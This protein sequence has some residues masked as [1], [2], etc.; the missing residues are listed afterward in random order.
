MNTGVAELRRDAGDDPGRATRL[1]DRLRPADWV[2]LTAV[3]G[4]VLPVCVAL[5]GRLGSHW[6]PGGD[7]AVIARLS[8]DVLSGHPPLLGM[9]STIA[10][11]IE[12]PGGG[13]PHHL[14]PMLFWLFAIPDRLSGSSPA[15]LVITIALVNIAAI[16]TIAWQVR[17]RAGSSAAVI[18]MLG[19]LVLLWSVGRDLTV[20]IWNPYAALLP[21][22][23]FLVLA[24]SVTCA[25]HVAVPL[26]VLVGSFVMQCHILY[27]LPVVGVGLVAAAA[28]VLRARSSRTQ[29]TTGT[30]E[31]ERRARRRSLIAAA[32][33]LSLCWSTAVYDQV[34]HR[35]GNLTRLWN[36]F[37]GTHQKAFGTV[38]AY[39]YGMRAIAVPPL[40]ARRLTDYSAFIALG[41]PIGTWI[42]AGA[43]VVLAAL[44]IGTI[45]AW[46]R[47]APEAWLG[48]LGLVT[49]ATSLF[50]LA[51]LP[52]EFGGLDVYRGRFLWIVGLYAWLALFLV[53]RPTVRSVGR[54][55][56]QVWPTL[57]SRPLVVTVGVVVALGALGVGTMVSRE[58]SPAYAVVSDETVAIRDLSD[59]V[60]AHVTNRGPYLL[61]VAGARAY[62][63]VGYGVMWDLVRHGYDVRV[64]AGDPYLGAAHG[65]PNRAPVPRLL[66]VSSVPNFLGPRGA[67]LV[68][69]V[70]DDHTLGEQLRLGEAALVAGL[71]RR[72]AHLTAAGRRLL[73]E[74]EPGEIADALSSLSKPSPPW[75]QLLDDQTLYA[76]VLGKFVAIDGPDAAA[77]SRFDGLLSRSTDAVISVFVVPPPT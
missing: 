62:G 58:R 40:F 11:G 52:L 25:D 37:N 32:V 4:A 23:L 63:T 74:A 33:V 7:E 56:G 77:L 75:Q 19:V 24:W 59:Q 61:E 42:T 27:V 39:R 9:P 46:R 21:L 72:G 3:V 70:G 35:P 43:V 47:A 51:R 16:V 22:L 57:R 41:H 50:V 66:V 54:R 31:A 28:F 45:V 64:L 71:D 48:V 68:A 5:A 34:V 6:E 44:T 20:Q 18:A 2:L 17:R 26:S 13:T 1:R 53:W 12:V 8:H 65:L 38:F 60:R 67:Q 30:T 55:A 10:A 76:L 14:G 49:V 73:A 29:S 36:S 15:A 69:V